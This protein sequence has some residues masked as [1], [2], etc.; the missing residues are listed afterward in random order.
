MSYLV[1]FEVECEI[2]LNEDGRFPNDLEI[3]NMAVKDNLKE[4]VLDS[5]KIRPCHVEPI[6]ED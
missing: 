2:T 5:V 3:V 4:T 1:R 6:E